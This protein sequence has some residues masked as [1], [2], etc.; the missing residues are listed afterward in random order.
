M[1]KYIK[2]AADV[3]GSFWQQM[4]GL[5][6]VRPKR[7]REKDRNVARTHSVFFQILGLARQ[8]N[9]QRLQNYAFV[10]NVTNYARG[11]GRSVEMAIAYHGQTVSNATRRGRFA[12]FTGNDNEGR[13]SGNTLKDKQSRLLRTCRAVMLCYDNYQKGVT[14]QHQR[15]GHSSA[16]FKGTHQCG[17]KIFEFDDDTF[18][19]FYPQFTQHDQAIPSPWGMPAFEMVDFEDP[20]AICNVYENFDTYITL[21]TPEFEGKRVDSYIQL[22][23]TASHLTMLAR[24]FP[25]SAMDDDNGYFDQCPS[26][27][28]QENLRNFGTKLNSSKVAKLLKEA[29]AFQH[30][31]VLRWNEQAD[32]ATM[33]VYLGLLG[34]DEAASKECGA[35]TLDLLLRSGVLVQNEGGGWDLADDYKTRRIYLVGDAKT[36]ENMTK[37]VRD[38]QIR[39]I[40]YSTA[41]VQSEIFLEALSA[42]KKFPGDW[43]TGLN[44]LTSIY[45]LYYVGFLDQFQDML[46]WKRVNDDVSKCYYQAGRLV[47]FVSDELTRFFAHQYISSISNSDGDH[48]L[49]DAASV[50]KITRGFMSYL[51]ELKSSDDKWIS[52]CAHFLVM[53]Y[54]YLEFVKA[55]RLSDAIAIEFGYQK[56]AP[57]W[58]FLG[59]N[60]YVDVF[61]EQNEM[62]Y[63]DN[64][65]STLQE[66][67]MNRCVRRRPGSSGKRAVAQDEFLENGNRFFSE[68]STPHS[69]AAFEEQSNY[70]G[71][72]LKSKVFCD[73]WFNT[74]WSEA[75]KTYRKNVAPCMLP[76]KQLLYEVFKLLRTHIA[77]K[78]RIKFTKTWV[79]SV[80]NDLTTKLRREVL[81]RSMHESPATSADEIL[82][83][84]GSGL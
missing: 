63:R 64:P 7:V 55:Y 14:L 75:E 11:V 39:R 84:I 71:L 20:V 81:E 24:A 47:T 1:K 8:A 30:N 53:S 13:A 18:D 12:H 46:E 23:D 16:F 43:H 22:R 83:D 59:Q 4:I 5:R 52:T 76:E 2:D 27:Y 34:I 61:F 82:E 78:T 79:S 66:L 3:F 58:Q 36:V 28:S 54:D 6:G 51:R 80:S 38:M 72:A 10:Q 48:D 60:K 21:A 19:A 40:S 65:F 74:R 68:F 29:K 32:E 33:S 35:I 37:F 25:A 42:I 56:H 15:G 31:T 77:D 26:N 17:H 67:R 45:K 73:M 49:S 41:N 57:V 9:R 62:M 44:M 69:L 70:V 50:M